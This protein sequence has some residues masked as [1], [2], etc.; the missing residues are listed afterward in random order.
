MAVLPLGLRVEGE[1]VAVAY[2]GKRER[3]SERKT[4][5]VTERGRSKEWLSRDNTEAD[6]GGGLGVSSR[7]D[8]EA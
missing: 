5:C 2:L 7:G 6:Q 8:R 4:G 1:A 3:V